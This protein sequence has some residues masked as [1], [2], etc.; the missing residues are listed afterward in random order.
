MTPKRE[1]KRKLEDE[2]DYSPGRDEA[3][4]VVDRSTKSTG[5]VEGSPVAQARRDSLRSAKVA[6]A[7]RSETSSGP[8][9][10]SG[11]KRK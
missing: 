5:H 1:K 11:T 8:G 3:F 6:R 10:H 9:E 7:S 4:Q 2:D